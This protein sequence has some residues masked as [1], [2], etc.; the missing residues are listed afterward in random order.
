MTGTNRFF[1]FISIPLKQMAIAMSEDVVKL[2]AN[3]QTV[4]LPIDA[5]TM[6]SS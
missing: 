2:H 3:V 4:Q 5:G 1:H 6:Q